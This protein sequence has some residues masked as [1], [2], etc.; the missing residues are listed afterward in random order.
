MKI[1]IWFPVCHALCKYQLSGIFHS[2]FYSGS[3]ASKRYSSA[4]LASICWNLF[5]PLFIV[6]SGLLPDS[7]QQFFNIKFLWPVGP[8]RWNIREKCNPRYPGTAGLPGEI[9]TGLIMLPLQ[10]DL[11]FFGGYRTKRFLTGAACLCG[12][13]FILIMSEAYYAM[14]IASVKERTRFRYFT[15]AE[16]SSAGFRSFIVFRYIG[17]IKTPGGPG[18]HKFYED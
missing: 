13:F 4:E 2:L 17:K 6:K 1:R 10:A 11:V 16:V 5:N 3:L 14:R 7:E 12:L 18:V 9:R 8:C 15:W